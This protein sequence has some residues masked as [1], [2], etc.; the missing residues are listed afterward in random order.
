MKKTIALIGNSVIAV[1]AATTLAMSQ[2]N[3][4]LPTGDADNVATIARKSQMHFL[5]YLPDLHTLE[6]DK[7]FYR[8]RVFPECQVWVYEDKQDLVG[9]CAFKE[10]WVDHL[11]LLP[12]HVGN[13]LG[14]SLLNKAKENHPFLQLWVFQ[15]NTRAISFYERNGFQK[16]KETDGSKCEEMLPDAL[17]EWRRLS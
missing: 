17:F 12:T 8:N 5:P 11:Y 10:G 1:A 13:T 7:S 15:R 2:D 16:I 6:E 14:E 4:V 9:F 3:S